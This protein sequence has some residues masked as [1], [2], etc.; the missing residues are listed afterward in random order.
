VALL[1]YLNARKTIFQPLKVE[2][3]KKQIEDLA[4]ALELFVGKD[5]MALEEDFDFKFA[6][7]ANI[8]MMYDSY[9]EYAFQMER[10]RES[11]EY[12]VELCP[13]SWMK[14][15]YLE[16]L[17]DDKG[18]SVNRKAPKSPASWEYEHPGLSIPRK[19]VDREKEFQAVLESPLLP[20]KVALLIEEYV[21]DVRDNL[22]VLDGVLEACAK[23]MP[24]R[25]PTLE[26]IRDVRFDWILDKLNRS[27]RDNAPNLE[28]KAK[29]IVNEIRAYFDSDNV[30]PVR[31]TGLSLKRRSA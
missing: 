14:T 31:Q 9:I 26:D 17:L 21:A 22:H 2:I 5:W 4:K 24:Q 25:Y 10:P 19:F 13:V 1:G 15:K 29:V 28:E 7:R 16:P 3:F 27:R 8:A 6:V 11:R 20:A 23:E 12:R 30:F 18:G